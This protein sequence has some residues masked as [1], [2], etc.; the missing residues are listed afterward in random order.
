M[1]PRFWLLCSEVSAVELPAQAGL[2]TRKS[3]G[4][5]KAPPTSWV[6]WV[7]LKLQWTASQQITV[8]RPSKPLAYLV[9]FPIFHAVLGP[10][11]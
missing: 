6:S 3:R 11:N 7:N 4:K 2:Q 9:Q 8:Q 1:T 5:S 10:A